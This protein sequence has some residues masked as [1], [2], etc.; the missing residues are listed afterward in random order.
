MGTLQHESSL[1]ELDLKQRNDELS[2][3]N[4]QIKD[5]EEALAKE[6]QLRETSDGEAKK[7]LKQLKETFT[8]KEQELRGQVNELKG[9]KQKMEDTIYRLKR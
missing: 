2:E 6:N 1:L 3:L 4:K 9:E 5:L 8:T 7:Q